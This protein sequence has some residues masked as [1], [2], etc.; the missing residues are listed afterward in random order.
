[1][2]VRIEQVHERID[3]IHVEQ[4]QIAPN[5]HRRRRFQPRELRVENEEYYRDT[6]GEEDDRNSIV[7]NWRNSG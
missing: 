6:F 7:G 2:R 5:M 3:R 4:P 1:M